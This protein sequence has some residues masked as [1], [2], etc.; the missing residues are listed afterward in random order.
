MP[1]YDNVT[2]PANFYTQAFAQKGWR[3]LAAGENTDT[4][5]RSGDNQAKAVGDQESYRVIYAPDGGTISFTFLNNK[6]DQATNLVVPAGFVLEGLFATVS[7][8]AG[9]SDVFVSI[10]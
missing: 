5:T 4:M 1:K 10:A 7:V 9:S 2:A 8:A 3:I 6:G